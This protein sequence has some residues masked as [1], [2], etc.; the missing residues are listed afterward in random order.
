MKHQEILPLK[1]RAKQ[2]FISSFNISAKAKIIIAKIKA[3]AMLKRGYRGSKGGDMSIEKEQTGIP[4][5]FLSETS[6][7]NILSV[8]VL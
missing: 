2:I 6:S 8:S 7:P 5:E 1:K 3:S 4:K